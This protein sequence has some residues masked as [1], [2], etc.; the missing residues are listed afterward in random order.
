MKENIKG[1]REKRGGESQIKDEK[2]INKN[3]KR[4]AGNYQPS[5]D[6]HQAKKTIQKTN[7]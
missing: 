6:S 5:S 3:K 2:M 1:K 4:K 7:C